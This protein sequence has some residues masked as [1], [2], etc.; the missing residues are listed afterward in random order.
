[1]YQLSPGLFVEVSGAATKEIAAAA[2]RYV[3]AEG[4]VDDVVDARKGA[5]E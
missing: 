1:M 2:F 4:L 5:L 3:Q